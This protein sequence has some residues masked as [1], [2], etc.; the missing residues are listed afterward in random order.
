MGRGG[1]TKWENRGS[2]TSRQGKTFR[3]PLLKS[4]NFFRPPPL[5]VGVKLHGGYKTVEGGS[6]ELSQNLPLQTGGGG[7]GAD[8]F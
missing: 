7:G 6:G 1:A 8:R 2:E 3:A 5:F 4:G